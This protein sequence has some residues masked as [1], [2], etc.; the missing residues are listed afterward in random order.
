M[1]LCLDCGNSQGF[2]PVGCQCILSYL[3]HRTSSGMGGFLW[4]LGIERLSKS[5]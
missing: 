2:P 3:G 4:M 5:L 1:Q